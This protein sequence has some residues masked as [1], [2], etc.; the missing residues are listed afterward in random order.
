VFGQIYRKLEKE[1]KDKKEK[2]EQIIERSNQAYEERDQAIEQMAQ[3]KRQAD[4]EQEEFRR[5]WEKLGAAI[6][7]NRKKL[8]DLQVAKAENE[9]EEAKEEK[10][11]KS[12][13]KANWKITEAKVQHNQ[14]LDKA[15]TFTD[16]FNRIREETGCEDVEELVSKFVAVEDENFSLF[17]YVN[18]LNQEVEKL[19][20]QMAD[21]RGE[22][23][24]YQSQGNTHE[25][26][27]K[28]VL[29]ELEDRLKRT[30]GRAES[31]EKKHQAATSA[32]GMLRE[33][34]QSIFDKLGCDSSANREILGEG[35]VTDGNM[36]QYLGVIEQRINEILTS[37]ASSQGLD[38]TGTNLAA[39][40]GAGTSGAPMGSMPSLA[41]PG[42]NDAN[43]GEEGGALPDDVPLT[44]QEIEA[45]LSRKRGKGRR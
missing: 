17:N 20:E 25:K 1:L 34:I 37:Y 16:V 7:D 40:L 10:R 23:E 21:I 5:R 45:F 26:Q 35:G 38:A 27:R 3:L 44:R 28:Q 15:Q 19:E 2:M 12:L 22:I 24:R 9:R 32:M 41:M 8:M 13:A 39:L 42:V 4:L 29:Q 36:M 18:E 31:Y 43:D 11:N 30:E 6:S 33:G 14:N